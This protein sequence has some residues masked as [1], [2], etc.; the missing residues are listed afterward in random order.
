[1]A[2][3]ASACRASLSFPGAETGREGKG[4]KVGVELRDFVGKQRR[5]GRQPSPRA[6]T[7][8][9][10]FGSGA[11]LRAGAAPSPRQPQDRGKM[12]TESGRDAARV[13]FRALPQKTFSCLQ[14]RNIAERLLKWWGELPLRDA[15]V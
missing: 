1:M 15:S 12:S 2:A 10:T 14:D 4:E 7:G 8:G 13:V 11:G 6:L 5:E 9:G 3:P